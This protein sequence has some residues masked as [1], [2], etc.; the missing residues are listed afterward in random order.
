MGLN[1]AVV[2]YDFLIKDMRVGEEKDSGM[3]HVKVRE[4]EGGNIFSK[5]K[6]GE[7]YFHET[8]PNQTKQPKQTKTNQNKPK[9]T[10]NCEK[11]RTCYS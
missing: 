5:E 1:D 9:Q 11:G 4:K 2:H 6:W 3:E 7:N 8:K 10:E